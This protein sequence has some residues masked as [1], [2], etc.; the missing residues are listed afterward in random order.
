VKGVNGVGDGFIG[1]NEFTRM[2][3]WVAKKLLA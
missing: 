1:L 2:I 3:W